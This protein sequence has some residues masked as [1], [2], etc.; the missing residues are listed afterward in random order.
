MFDATLA[1]DTPRSAAIRRTAPGLV[2]LVLLTAVLLV[3]G[4]SQADDKAGRIDLSR[5]RLSDT[6]LYVPFRVLSTMPLAAALAEGKLEDGPATGLLVREHPEGRIALV[7]QQMAYH[8][9]ASGELDGEPWLATFYAVSNS[10]VGMT[11]VIAGKR[12]TFEVGGLYDG[13]PLLKDVEYGSYW[14]HIT[15]ECLHGP[16]VGTRLETC[17][18]LPMTAAQ[19]LELYPELQVAISDVAPRPKIFTPYQESP[20]MPQVF[21]GFMRGAMGAEDTR[22][23]TLDLGLGIWTSDTQRYY[24]VEAIAA[25]GGLIDRLNGRNVLIYIDP[26]SN[27]PAAIFTEAN[28]LNWKGNEIYLDNGRM[29]RKGVLYASNGDRIRVERPL[30]I[31]TRWYGFASTFPGCSLYDQANR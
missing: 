19:A 16:L 5:A 29:L 1:P 25:N 7:T 14:S 18:L 15:G 11:P 24:P 9:L 10:G 20:E 22:R 2:R 30:Q 23:P 21:E 31:F 26:T 8:Q 28:S 6:T 13:I 27:M 3:P 17:N 12:L 4:Q